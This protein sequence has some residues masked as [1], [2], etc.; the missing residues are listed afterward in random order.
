MVLYEMPNPINE[1]A[2]GIAQT[3]S[4]SLLFAGMFLQTH[5]VMAPIRAP[6]AVSIREHHV[7]KC[8]M[9]DQK[10]LFF[11]AHLKRLS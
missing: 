6:F 1:S 3:F 4:R 7:V 5:R 2:I 8:L 10:S 11:S 9:V